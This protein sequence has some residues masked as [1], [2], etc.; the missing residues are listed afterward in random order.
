MKFDAKNL[1][2]SHRERER[3]HHVWSESVCDGPSQSL[4]K[5]H[6]L[7]STTRVV[8]TRVTGNKS[9]TWNYTRQKPDTKYLGI[10]GTQLI[11]SRYKSS[12]LF[13]VKVKN[14]L[15]QVS[16][17]TCKN[18]AATQTFTSTPGGSPRD[19]VNFPL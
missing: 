13:L 10:P 8:P 7:D 5:L 14:Q 18:V 4:I 3:G 6:C 19:D 17:W 16:R 1:I 2:F 12:L 9:K 15:L 11:T